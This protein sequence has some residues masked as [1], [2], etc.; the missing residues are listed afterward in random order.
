MADASVDIG[1]GEDEQ[2]RPNI[3]E[4][5]VGESPTAIAVDPETNRV[6]VAN[7]GSSIVSVIDS[8]TDTVVRNI[9]EGIVA[10]DAIAVDPETNRVY[11]ANGISN[12]VSVIDSSTNTVVRN[13]T[14]THF[15]SAIAVDP[16]TNRVYVAHENS[17]SVSVIDSSTDTVVSN[18]TEGISY[19]ADIAVDPETNRVYVANAGSIDDSV[20]A[21]VSVI[22]SS[23]DT[24]VSNITE[25]ISYP[26]DIA[27]DPETNKIYTIFGAGNRISVIDA[28]TS[29]ETIVYV[30]KASSLAV[31]PETNRVYVANWGRFDD[32]ND[33]V[34]VIDSSTDTVVGN[35]R[36]GESASAIAVDPETNRVYVGNYESDTISVIDGLTNSVLIEATISNQDRAGEDRAGEVGIKIQRSPFAIAVD[37][38]T[39]RVYVAHENSHSVSVI[40]SS[41]DTVVS[42]IR[43]GETP[44]AI[45]VDP[46]TNRVYAANWGSNTTSVIDSSTDTVVG[47]IRVGH[48]PSAIAVDPETNRVYVGNWGSID[49]FVSY[50]DIT[51]NASVSVID[52]STDTVVSNITEGIFRPSDIA[53]D[54][55]TNRVYVANWGS[56]DYSVNA[57]VSVIDSS[58]DTVVSNITDI[59]EGISFRTDIAVDP[60]TNRVY[61][62]N[63]SSDSVSVID[64]YFVDRVIN[65]TVGETPSAIAV[66]PETNR[67]YVANWGS[68]TTS[69]IDSSTDTVVGNIRVGHFPSAIAVDPETNILYVAN[70]GSDTVTMIDAL[71]NQ[72]VVGITFNIQPPNAGHIKC[73][74][75]DNQEKEIPSN[76]YIRIEFGAE[77]RAEANIDYTFNLNKLIHNGFQPSSNFKFDWWSGLQSG[78]NNPTSFTVSRHGL[79]LT[80]NF[81]EVPPPPDYQSTIIIPTMLGL[82]PV[83]WAALNR[84]KHRSYLNRYTKTI[85]AAYDA[86]YSKKDESKRHLV[87]IRREMTDQF[88]KGK[89]TES[90]YEMLDKKILEYI[91]KL[92]SPDVP[93]PST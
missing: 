59:I 73:I 16:E 57:S 24:V 48:F 1:T 37:P 55:E 34:S 75:K 18:I 56:I 50:Y 38:E 60:K 87:E 62:A 74:D 17:H 21:S 31:D 53:I 76:T 32:G 20:N 15:P 36:V 80:A 69:V 71:T 91:K 63:A 40:D 44:S 14:V 19:P 78:S 43:V 81:S 64:P 45:A 68:N 58:T 27:V 85:D 33:T 79:N 70:W 72:Q 23:T 35:I 13:I 93:P 90:H 66:D 12:T 84:R 42:N 4:I 77:C 88:N 22:D 83:G 5:D 49:D 7:W 3:F 92:E 8:S 61:V 6:Y 29:D 82:I 9:T 54:P 10:P 47:N 39:N 11:V 26:S 86:A 2:A 46:E 67:V 25:G 89:I 41:T 28:N 52:S 65:I 51:L 30:D